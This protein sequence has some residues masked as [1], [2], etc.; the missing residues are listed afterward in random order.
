MVNQGLRVLGVTID[1]PLSYFL[2][3]FGLSTAVRLVL[4]LIKAYEVA[5][6]SK[7]V[8]FWA[9]V[10]R[11]FVGLSPSPGKEAQKSDFLSPFLVGL[12]EL[13]SFP[14]LMA[15]THWSYIGW[16]LGFKTAAQYKHWTTER[17]VFNRYLVGNAL[18]LVLAVIVL[19]PRVS[20]VA[21]P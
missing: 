19:V 10:G 7:Q 18:V 2:M 1:D 15:G 3:A 20:K 12:L 13:L 9:S 6:Q 17:A 4:C 11:G 5:G 14:V 21:L 16:W 8:A